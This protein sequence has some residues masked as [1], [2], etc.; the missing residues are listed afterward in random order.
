M[1]LLP[2]LPQCWKYRW[3]SAFWFYIAFL[4]CVLLCCQACLQGWV[5]GSACPNF[6]Y[7]MLVKSSWLKK[8]INFLC[9]WLFACMYTTCVVG[10]CRGQKRALNPIEVKLWMIVSHHVGEDAL[11]QWAISPAPTLYDF[12]KNRMD[13]DIECKMRA[14]K[15][16]KISSPDLEPRME[17]ESQEGIKT[18][19]EKSRRGNAFGKS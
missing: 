18:Q 19:V 5:N 12:K 14:S 7:Y 4:R 9:V 13:A 3:V 17:Q 16:N 15:G 1:F 6:W 11:N 2:Q 10:T 8:M